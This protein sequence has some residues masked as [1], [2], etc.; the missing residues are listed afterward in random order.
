MSFFSSIKNVIGNYFLSMELQSIHRNKTFMNLEEAK[1]VGILFD[2]TERENFDLVKKYIVYL[3]DMKKSVKAIGFY[4][5][6][7]TPPMAYSKLEY[8]FFTLK[9]LNWYNFPDNIY[10]RNFI[11]DEY[12]I[13]LDLNIYDS[14]PLKYVSAVSK[15]KFKVGKKSDRN[16]STFDLMIDAEASKG[17]KY[18]LRNI[19]TYLSII[20]KKHDKIIVEQ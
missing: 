15:A 5:Q 8:D 16:S 12:D 9:D 13:L 10:V 14:F 11:E 17:L 7:Q 4:N 18:F 19:D 3:K 20:N 2:A 1:T 6:K